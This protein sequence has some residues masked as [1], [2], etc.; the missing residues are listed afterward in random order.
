M[1]RDATS[2]LFAEPRVALLA[3]NFLVGGANRSGV[4]RSRIRLTSQDDE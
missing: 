1:G 3:L 4:I 2:Q